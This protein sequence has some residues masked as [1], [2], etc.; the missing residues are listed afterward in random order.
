MANQVLFLVYR[1]MQDEFKPGMPLDLDQ[2]MLEGKLEKLRIDQSFIDKMEEIKVLK[3]KAAREMQYEVAATL[4]EQ[5]RCMLE[6]YERKKPNGFQS[7]FL[8]SRNGTDY[9]LVA[10]VDVILEL[11]KRDNT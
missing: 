4:R 3:N 5:E 6:A 1:S 11:E 9:F 8:F 10:P 2:L 7:Y